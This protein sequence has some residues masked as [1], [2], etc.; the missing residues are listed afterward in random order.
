MKHRKGD[1]VPSCYK[2]C[3]AK[4]HATFYAR[5]VPDT[6]VSA[7]QFSVEI[8]EFYH[9]YIDGS[10]DSVD[11]LNSG[12]FNVTQGKDGYACSKGEKKDV[13][14]DTHLPGEVAEVDFVKEY[15]A[16]RPEHICK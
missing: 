2:T 12:T 16:T 1:S 7:S 10:A 13:C 15:P 14:E 4:N 6:F 3:D 8:L 5:V 9:G 11:K